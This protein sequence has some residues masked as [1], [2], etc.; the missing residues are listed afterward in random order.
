MINGWRMLVSD[1][2]T[3]THDNVK[4]YFSNDYVRMD[5]R[6]VGCTVSKG[7]GCWSEQTG[8]LNELIVSNI[9]I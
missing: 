7:I 3:W 9:R 6:I 1:V 2:R 4:D 8:K 5:E